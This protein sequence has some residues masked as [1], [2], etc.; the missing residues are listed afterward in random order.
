MISGLADLF[1]HWVTWSR[2]KLHK[3]AHQKRLTPELS[4]IFALFQGMRIAME[5]G[6]FQSQLESARREALKSFGDDVMLVEKYIDT[7]R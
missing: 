2:L 5:P 4:V 1:F 3:F 6:E 7:P